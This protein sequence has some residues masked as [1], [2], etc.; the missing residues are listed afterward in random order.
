MSSDFLGKVR[1]VLIYLG[2]LANKM[3][4]LHFWKRFAVGHVGDDAPSLVEEFVDTILTPRP[5]PLI[6]PR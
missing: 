6:H 2:D 4:V 3:Q 5:A 1:G